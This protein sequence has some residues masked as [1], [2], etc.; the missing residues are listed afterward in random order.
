M[1]VS[2]HKAET[3]IRNYSRVDQ[4][5]KREM[6][7]ALSTNMTSSFTPQGQGKEATSS[8][9]NGPSFTGDNDSDKSPLDVL[10]LSQTEHIL[11][12]LTNTPVDNIE[13]QVSAQQPTSVN[14]PRATSSCSSAMYTLQDL[15]NCTVNIYQSK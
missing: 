1:G 6:S 5:K 10:S 2:G 14:L 13:P 15:H 8:A 9:V 3:S 12:D 4:A 11:A 7:M